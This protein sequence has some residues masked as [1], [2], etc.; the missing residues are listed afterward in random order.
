[1]KG[2]R[3]G[4]K[5]FSLNEVVEVLFHCTI[6]DTDEEL[7]LLFAIKDDGCLMIQ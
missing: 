3:A 6:A 4:K 1:M 5:I 2:Q 7:W